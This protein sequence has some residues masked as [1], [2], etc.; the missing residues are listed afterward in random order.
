MSPAD[1]RQLADMVNTYNLVAA[2]WTVAAARAE[3]ARRHRVA[4]LRD[5]VLRVR[6]RCI[7]R[8]A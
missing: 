6:Q 5:L 7:V 1:R 4:E 2:G 8:V 3:V